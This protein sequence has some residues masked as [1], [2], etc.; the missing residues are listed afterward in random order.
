M[1]ALVPSVGECHGGSCIHAAVAAFDQGGPSAV[2]FAAVQWVAAGVAPALLPHRLDIAQSLRPRGF[3]A[4]PRGMG[5]R[6]G[7][8]GGWHSAGLGSASEDEAQFPG[9]GLERRLKH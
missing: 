5:E 3:R 9:D 4:G 7:P 1:R 2:W 8:W 6:A